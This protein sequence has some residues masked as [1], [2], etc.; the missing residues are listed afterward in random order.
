M[1]TNHTPGPWTYHYTSAAQ[2]RKDAI[3]EGSNTDGGGASGS[4]SAKDPNS[5]YG[6]TIVFLPHHRDPKEDN[7]RAANARLIA[8]APELLEACQWM[9][10]Q[11]E[12]TS[13]ASASHWEQFPGYHQAHAAISKAMGL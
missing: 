13:G 11:L 4:I 12:G 2:A 8:A 3:E 1:K 5:R 9:M 6:R 7:E 10:M